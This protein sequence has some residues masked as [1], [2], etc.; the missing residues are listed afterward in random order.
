MANKAPRIGL[1]QAQ[2]LC[3]MQQPERLA[4][5]ADGLPVVLASAQGFWRAARQLNEQVREAGVL[6]HHAEEEA[7]KALILMDMIRCPGQLISSRMG[8]MIKWFYSHL[9]RLIYAEAMSWKPVNVAQLR[10]YVDLNRKSHY[11][12]GAVG[13]YIMPNSTIFKR[14]GML[15]ADIATYEDEGASWSNPSDLLHPFSLPFLKYAPTAL[16]LAESM[17]R[18]GMFTQRGV[19]LTSEVWGKVEFRDQESFRDAD[20][21]MQILLEKLTG[22]ELV[23]DEAENK[24]MRLLCRGWQLPMYNLDFGL[25]QVSLEDLRNEQERY[26]WAEI[27]EYQ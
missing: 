1:N 16:R 20:F 14:E 18:L 25:L 22:E 24:D 17:S 4:C 23:A 19:V 2:R 26:L 6:A 27:G 13:E 15:Y 7:A 3:Q 21:L 11:V 10:E 12:D 9:A 8:N 5:I